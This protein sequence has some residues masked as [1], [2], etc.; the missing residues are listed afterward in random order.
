MACKAMYKSGDIKTSKMTPSVEVDC[1]D[2]L[3]NA[4]F[5]KK[6]SATCAPSKTN[7]IVLSP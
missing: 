1:V 5:L 4:R 3:L 6:M 2:K 7:T